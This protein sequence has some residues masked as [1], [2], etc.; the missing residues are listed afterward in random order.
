MHKLVIH[1]RLPGYNELLAAANS[2]RHIGNQLKQQAQ[3]AVMWH[4]RQQ[5]RGVHISKPVILHYAYWEPNRKRDRDNVSG[6][7][8][9]IVQDALVK[10]GV[11]KNDGWRYVLGSTDLD[12]DVDANDPRVVVMIEEVNE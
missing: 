3:N 4:I 5:L 6:G 10:M 9:K 11:L 7:A 8:H 2:D 12:W 1:G